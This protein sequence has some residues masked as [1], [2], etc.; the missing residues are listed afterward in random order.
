MEPAAVL[1]VIGIIYF[2]L[3]SAL[4]FKKCDWG[5]RREYLDAENRE[6][7]Q[8]NKAFLQ[9]GIACAAAIATLSDCTFH[10]QAV[11]LICSS[12]TIAFFFLLIANERL[13]NK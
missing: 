10:N 7:W 5:I 2:F 3:M 11:T 4:N 6:R 8:R 12:I 13:I 9:L 1:V